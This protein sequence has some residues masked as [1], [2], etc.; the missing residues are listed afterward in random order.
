MQ[1][2]L[3]GLANAFKGSDSAAKGRT[4][5]IKFTYSGIMR[6]R[7]ATAAADVFDLGF[8]RSPQR[9][10]GFFDHLAL[11]GCSRDKPS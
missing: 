2:Q 1:P 5:S 8:G 10:C 6:R 7:F 9:W 11:E 4:R 3:G